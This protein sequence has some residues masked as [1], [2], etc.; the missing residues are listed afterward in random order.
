MKPLDRMPKV[1]QY[2][3]TST[4]T[5]CEEHLTRSCTCISETFT[6]TVPLVPDVPHLPEPTGNRLAEILNE[7][8]VFIC[9]FVILPSE[10][11]EI[12][13]TLWAAHCHVLDSFEST[14]RIAFLS[15]EP[16]SG[17]SRALEVL[18]T[19][20]P[21][22]MHAVNATPAALFR[23]VSDLGDQPTILFD[24]IDTVFGP[25]ARENEEVRGFLNAGHRRGA[26]AY[27]C[28]GMGTSQS[29]TAFPAFC[30]VAIAGL[31][32]VP[33]TIATRSIIVRMRKRKSTERV[34]PWRAR[35][36]EPHGHLLRDELNSLLNRYKRE[37]EDAE[38]VMPEGV[39]DRPADVWEPL[40]A[41]ADIAGDE[42]PRIARNAA[43]E[44]LKSSGS[45][46]SLGVLLLEHL[47]RLWQDQGN[48]VALSTKDILSALVQRDETPWA[49][50]K[51]DP[52]DPRRLARLLKQYGVTSTKVRVH[53]EV[54]RG[55]RREDLWD[56][57]SRY[58]PHSLTGLPDMRNI[59]NTMLNTTHVDVPVVPH[60]P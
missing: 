19:L 25:K 56:A 32:D 17:K 59:R 3:R 46:P 57:W 34:D 54:T 30:A 50:I 31:N 33:D 20:V 47:L 26:V 36:Q 23:A 40:F 8:R 45:E 35:A 49:S 10:A 44:L 28:V 55:Y 22:P 16:G 1:S 52:L 5:F 7:V 11:A 41:I 13:V 24:E 58:T 14:P 9:H 4:V 60:V 38:P 21:H 27:R 42:W 12:A 29:V 6:T 51:G 53:E 48:P 18:T 39:E 37:L 43:L 2:E 15:P